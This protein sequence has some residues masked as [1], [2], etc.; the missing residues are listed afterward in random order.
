MPYIF[1]HREISFVGTQLGYKIYLDGVEIEKIKNGETL[2]LK[3]GEG[4]H[5]L[6]AR[7]FIL[8]TPMLSFSI[9]PEETRRFII[10]RTKWAKIRAKIFTIIMLPLIVLFMLKIFRMDGLRYSILILFILSL[11]YSPI[12]I[13]EVKKL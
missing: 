4:E 9:N 13:S 5:L 2:K 10:K 7:S 12:V 6:R 3:I 8:K 11:L 1:I